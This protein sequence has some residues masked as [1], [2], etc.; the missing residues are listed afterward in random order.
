MTRAYTTEFIAQGDVTY[1][2]ERGGEP[3]GIHLSP[4]THAKDKTWYGQV[5]I[6][7]NVGGDYLLR[8]RYAGVTKNSWAER[9]GGRL[10]D[11]EVITDPFA[12]LWQ[13]V[14]L[15]AGPSHE[16]CEVQ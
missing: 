6:V 5:L 3:A 16:V 9:R 4:T 1:C 8:R 2:W 11:D 15:P 12:A 14:R 10:Q 13:G 7:G